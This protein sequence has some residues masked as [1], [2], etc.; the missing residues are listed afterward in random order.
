MLPGLAADKGW[1]T[2]PNI[3]NTNPQN[4]T[5]SSIQSSIRNRRRVLQP[6]R[7]MER[8]EFVQRLAWE[9]FGS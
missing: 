2:N 9:A 7:I 8:R 1:I 3:L 4:E 6:N 5:V